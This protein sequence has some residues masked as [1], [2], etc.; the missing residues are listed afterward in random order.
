MQEDA[1]HTPRASGE[2]T[3]TTP[4]STTRSTEPP[5]TRTPTGPDGPYE[6]GDDAAAVNF[7]MLQAEEEAAVADREDDRRGAAPGP[8]GRAAA[9]PGE[10]ADDPPAVLT[11]N[12]EPD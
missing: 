4:S 12:E 6:H 10:G 5:V 9:R 2:G 1:E 3:T 8:G 7:H 11:R